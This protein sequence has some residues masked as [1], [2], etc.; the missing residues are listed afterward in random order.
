MVTR[1]LHQ[2][3]AGVGLA[4]MSLEPLQPHVDAKAWLPFKMAQGSVKLIH[5]LT[6]I[7]IWHMNVW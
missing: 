5:L 1:P 7:T 3:V 2:S 4:V 6:V